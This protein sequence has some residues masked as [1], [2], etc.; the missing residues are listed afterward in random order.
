VFGLGTLAPVRLQVFAALSELIPV[1]LFA[2]NPSRAY[3]SD[4]RSRLEMA[5]TARKE[6]HA[7]SR[8]F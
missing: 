6:G 2:L 7:S 8:T 3:W 1:H 4:T 5:R